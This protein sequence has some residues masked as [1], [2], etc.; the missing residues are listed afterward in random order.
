M[1][2]LAELVVS[3]CGSGEIVCR[4]VE[5]EPDYKA[6]MVITQAAQVLRWRPQVALR[7]GLEQLIR[8]LR[9]AHEDWLAI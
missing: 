2:E 8:H 4:G 3:C 7:T 1:S 5:A 6:D 9:G